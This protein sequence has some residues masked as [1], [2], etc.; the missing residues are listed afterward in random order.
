LVLK[1]KEGGVKDG[2]QRDEDAL[3]GGD[4]FVEGINSGVVQSSIGTNRL[5]EVG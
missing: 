4:R 5:G 1:V 2:F 3:F